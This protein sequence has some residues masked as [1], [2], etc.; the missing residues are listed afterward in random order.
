MS[1]AAIAGHET[2]L[3]PTAP[4]P[5]K[6]ESLRASFLRVSAGYAVYAFAQWATVAVLA[7]LG[8]AEL[9]GQYAFAVALITPVLMLAQTNLRSLL[10][11][12]VT[13]QHPFRDY[14]NLRFLTLTLGMIVIAV[15]AAQKTLFGPTPSTDRFWVI[16]LVGLIQA[17]E[18]VADIYYGR[19]QQSERTSRMAPSLIA[20]GTLGIL[21]LA[22]TLRL[23][24]SLVAALLCAFLFRTL[25]YF[26]YDSTIG[27]RGIA[28]VLPAK[29][30]QPDRQEQARVQW[31]IFKQ[32]LP[33]GVVLMLGALVT[34]TPRY[35]LAAHN[36]ER[37]LGIFSAIFSL[38][39]AGNLVVT[40]LGQSAVPKLARLYTSGDVP[41][42]QSL[43]FKIAG[44]GAGLGLLGIAGVLLMGRWAV[45]LLYRPEYAQQQDF[46]LAAVAA[47][48]IGFAASL[49]GYSITAAR[50]FKEQM[51]LQVGCLAGTALV[52]YFLVPRLGLVGAALSVGIG[53]LIQFLGEAWILR[54]VLVSMRHT[55]TAGVRA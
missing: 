31:S 44:L 35:F 53:S 45:S 13:G 47:A 14:R 16:V 26:V 12:D 40:S 22:V 52:A 1:A 33:L 36:G 38:A 17:G 5:E 9:V 11:T 8:T 20:R 3:P 7:K 28:E 37:A 18:W 41:G 50:R 51:P 29:F 4:P 32:A 23:T 34:N 10:A 30:A 48:G 27:M 42:F 46:L 39:T 15:L 24:H 49:L 2:S 55:L 25:V 54:N 21:A 19:M 6:R 43:S